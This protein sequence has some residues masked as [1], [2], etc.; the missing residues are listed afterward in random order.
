[1]HRSWPLFSP[2]FSSSFFL[3]STSSASGILLKVKSPPPHIL[4]YMAYNPCQTNFYLVKVELG[5]NNSTTYLRLSYIQI[6]NIYGD[7]DVEN[8]QSTTVLKQICKNLKLFNNLQVKLGQI[9][10]VHLMKEWAWTLLSRSV[11][12]DDCNCT[13]Q[14]RQSHG[15]LTWVT[16]I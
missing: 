14:N 2:T 5:F 11:Q 9:Y 1:M 12:A 16:I 13:E 8:I 10:N 4:T 15:C 7:T 6:C 3:F